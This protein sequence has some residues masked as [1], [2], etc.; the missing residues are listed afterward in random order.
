MLLNDPEPETK[1][2]NAVGFDLPHNGYK[3]VIKLISASHGMTMTAWYKYLI[4]MG[5]RL[6]MEDEELSELIKEESP[7]V[8]EELTEMFGVSDNERTREN[9]VAQEIAGGNETSRT[10]TA[11]K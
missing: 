8:W 7:D 2:N 9:P 5:I 10:D 3:R 11:S 1:V 6:A 4:Q